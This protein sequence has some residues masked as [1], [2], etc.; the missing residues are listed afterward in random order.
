M[1]TLEI[2]I[3]MLE[4]ALLVQQIETGEVSDKAL[5]IRRNRYWRE[6]KLLKYLTCGFAIDI[7]RAKKKG[8]TL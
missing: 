1:D 2:K 4:V 7:V 5:T 8:C 6:N 3:N